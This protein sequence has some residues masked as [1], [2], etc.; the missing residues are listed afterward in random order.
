ME[1]NTNR[2]KLTLPEYGRNVQKMV[3]YA[4]TIADRAERQQCAETIIRIMGRMFPQQ[5]GTEDFERMLWDHLAL[6]SN[7]RLDVDSPY[8]VTLP[9]EADRQQPHLDYPEQKIAYRHY[10]HTL[11]LMIRSLSAME[12]GEERAQAVELV[13][14]QMA[15]SLATWNSNV[16]SP[17]KLADDLYE[18]TDGGIQLDIEPQRL[19]KII[20]SARAISK[21]INTKKKKK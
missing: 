3:D 17:S 8:P 12:D 13:V 1:Y 6:I 19:D 21:P 9:T 2:P 5:K 10:G 18:M 14:A 20:A 4:M 11:E 15:K 7:Y 16:L